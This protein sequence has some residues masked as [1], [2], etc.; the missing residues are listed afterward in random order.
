MLKDALTRE[1]IARRLSPIRDQLDRLGV[2]KLCVFGSVARNEARAG[3]DVDFLVSFRGEPS[4]AQFMDLKLLLED[5]L[6]VK[7][8]L[9]TDETLRPRLRRTIDR[10]LFRVA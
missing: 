9:A 4:F 8:D 7:A 2:D 1:E 6:G 10:D 3:S 5:T